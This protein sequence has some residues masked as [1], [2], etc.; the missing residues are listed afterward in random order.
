MKLNQLRKRIDQIDREIL[1]L[2][3]ERCQLTHQIGSYKKNTGTAC[4]WVPERENQVLEHLLRLRHGLLSER[5]LRSIFNQILSAGRE[6][7]GGLTVAVNGTNP[8][9]TLLQARTLFGDC[10]DYL[11]CQNTRQLLKKLR[12]KQAQLAVSERIP[13]APDLKTHLN[14]TTQKGKKM[15]ILSLAQ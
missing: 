11:L 7:Q 5:A 10:T 13:K 2:L 3:E 8:Y 4:I 9:A 12:T 14:I 1:R 6:T 15:Y